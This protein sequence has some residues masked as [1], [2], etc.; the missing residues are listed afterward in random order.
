MCS[1]LSPVETAKALLSGLCSFPSPARRHRNLRAEQKVNAR[2]FP[3]FTCSVIFASR[4]SCNWVRLTCV[5][6]ALPHSG[7]LSFTLKTKSSCFDLCRPTLRLLHPIRMM[8]SPS[9]ISRQRHHRNRLKPRIHPPP[10]LPQLL[11]PPRR[12][13]Q[14]N[15]RRRL[16]PRNIERE[17][18]NTLSMAP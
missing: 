11:G 13:L 3:Q 6:P 15:H 18:H 12:H 17:S 14:H 9:P 1:T 16:H 10:Q 8:L 4:G 5:S 7:F 2:S